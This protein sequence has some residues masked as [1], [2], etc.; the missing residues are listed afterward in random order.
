MV[1]SMWNAL[2]QS[3]GRIIRDESVPLQIRLFR[4]YCATTCGLCLLVVLPMNLAQNL[5][6]SVH[7]GNGLLG[8]FAGY[9]C[10]A[11]LR[12]RDH[13]RFFFVL[14]V[15][16]LS[17]VWFFNAGSDGSITYYFFPVMLYPLLVLDGRSR[18]IFAALVVVDV[19]GLLVVEYHFPALTVPFQNRTD[20]VIDLTTGAFASCVAMAVVT[21]L[22]VSAYDRERQRL[23]QLTEKLVASERNYREIFAST[24]DALAIRD[25]TGRLIDCND[26]MCE[27]FGCDR[28]T[29]RRLS[30]DD[31][32]LGAS[33]YSRVEAMENIRRTFSE[34]PQVV[35]WRSRRQ[36]GELFWTELS[37]RAGEIV[38]EKRL[39]VSF[40]DITQRMES[41]QMMR[42]QE[43]RLR[44]ALAASHQGWFDINV[45][46]GEGTASA[47]YA[48]IIGL[49][50]VDFKVTTGEWIEAVHPDE[51]AAVQKVF[52][53]CI[54]TGAIR[55][56]EYRRRSKSGEWK[57]LRSIGK[58][59][60]YDAQGKALRM[61]GTH[62][63]I[64]ERKEL[65]TR[66]VHAQ[67]LESVATLAGGV[68]HEL[69][70]IFT[71][72]LMSAEV[73]GDKISDPRDREMLA[74]MQKGAR[75]GA[76]IVRQLLA[77]SRSVAPK[78]EPVDVEKLIDEAA[79]AA[80]EIS[81]MNMAVIVRVTPGLWRVKADLAQL[82]S[83][84]ESLC[85]NAHEAMPQGGTVIL[86][87]E[88]IRLTQPASTTN[89]WEK[90]GP[91][92]L[93]SVTDSG[94]GIPPET[95]NRIFDPFFTTKDVGKGPGL[96]LSA[97]LG[98][99]TGNGGNVTV[100]SRPGEGATFK[101][102]LPAVY[103]LAGEKAGTG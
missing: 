85:V 16:P 91:F 76:A 89:P 65:E 51:R 15:G 13:L 58:I 4:L 59:I 77:F 52:Q 67:R 57:W 40:R 81:P 31:I 28:E 36:N 1:R 34:G 9:C 20:R 73:F 7:V 83:V 55:T 95:V 82:Q 39:V 42:L 92:V 64:T 103:N 35:V 19:C 98:I 23:A 30:I 75:R 33:P 54:A 14:V 63:D 90:G 99:V 102:F 47:E 37:L 43:E 70:N 32:S 6:L 86:A 41:E 71:P 66:V 49:K 12:G 2:R 10:W 45:Q 60:E 21:W 101:V 69:N 87:A 29:M 97:V 74:G 53:E 94:A 80:R 44:L 5:P 96:G 27:M 46:T 50:P 8:L 11:S 61:L 18:W 38:G 24:S 17:L 25:A 68:A 93:I 84:L 100:E 88:N 3:L 26:Q 56:F 48:R 72:I 62:A 79:R 78:R 22:M